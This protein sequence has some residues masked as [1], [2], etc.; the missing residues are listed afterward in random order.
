T[1]GSNWPQLLHRKA[2]KQRRARSP[3]LLPNSGVG[4]IQVAETER[5][6]GAQRRVSLTLQRHRNSAAS[7]QHFRG[8]AFVHA[9]LHQSVRTDINKCLPRITLSESVHQPSYRLCADLES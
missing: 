2:A 8:A 1:S 9:N 6:I 7:I 5:Q 4:I 3:Q